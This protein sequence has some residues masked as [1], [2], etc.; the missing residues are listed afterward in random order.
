MGKALV[1][2]LCSAVFLA[3]CGKSSLPVGPPFDGAAGASAQ[4]S[5]LS[6]CQGEVSEIS[7]AGQRQDELLATVEDGTVSFT[8]S[9]ALFNR[10]LDSLS[11]TL[12]ADG[13]TIRV[14]ENEHCAEPGFCRCLY[15]VY[16]QGLDLAPG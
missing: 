16:G 1:I 12:Q 4:L 8:H 2:V 11:L 3:G 5:S 6:D 14:V 9:G 15:T 7:L 13:H 10:C